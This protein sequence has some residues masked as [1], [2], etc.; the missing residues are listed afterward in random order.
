MAQQGSFAD[1]QSQDNYV[2]SLALGAADFDSW[3]IEQNRTEKSLLPAKTQNPSPKES[4][5]DMKRQTGDPRVYK[6]YFKSIGIL[7]SLTFL[8]LATAYIF[9]GKLPR[10]FSLELQEYGTY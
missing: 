5:L 1:L 10:K 3:E 6:Y 8:L 7:Y 2:K 9:L 4:G